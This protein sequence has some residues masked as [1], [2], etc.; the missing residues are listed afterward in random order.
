M[1][2]RSRG[3]AFAL[4]AYA[5]WGFFP[6]YF[7]AL[8][9]V[10]ALEV[11]AH[12]VVW[13]VVLLSIA[14][15]LLGRWT[16][17]LEALGPRKR[18]LVATSAL[19]IAANWGVYIWAVQAGRVL[20]ASLGYY[21]NPLVSV[22]L[23]VLFLGER[24]RRLQTVAIA[25]AAMGVGVL[26]VDRGELPW[27]PLSLALTFGLYGLVRK[28]AGVDPVGGLLAETALLA[29]VA[30]AFVALL[31]TRDQG[32][33]GDGAGTT[34]LLLAAGPVTA[35]PL[36][37]FALGVR[38]LPLSTVGLLQY[39]TPTLQ[40]LLAVLVYREHFTAAHAVAFAFIWSALALYSWDSLR[41]GAAPQNADT[42]TPPVEG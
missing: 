31:T 28:R 27:L 39:L 18:L 32:S 1:P 23:G 2:S 6:I 13:S 11:L 29:P 5:A 15:P 34:L 30:L 14:T 24:L 42:S 26:V 41:A 8:A 40:F 10:P 25:L 4:L 9:H 7:K 21:V 17:T 35:I 36:I 19:L 38:S 33:F 37:W 20:Q 3:L 16:T 22:L 12:R